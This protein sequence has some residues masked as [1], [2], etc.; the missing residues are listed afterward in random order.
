MNKIKLI[1][2]GSTGLIGHRIYLYLKKYK[3]YEIINIAFK[4]VLNENT[5]N[6]DLRDFNLLNNLIKKEKPDYII[7]AAG[8]LIADSDNDKFSAI[9]LNSL[10]PNWLMKNSILYNYKLIHISTDCVF[11]GKYGNY[12]ENDIP[13]GISIYSKTKSL[14]EIF[15]NNHVTIRTSV[16]GPEIDT[17]GGELFNWFMNQKEG[18]KG[19]TKSI[20]SGITT[21]ELA[22]CLKIIIDNKITGLYHLTNGLPI[23]KYDLLSKLNNYRQIPLDIIKIDG[24]VTNKSFIDTRTLLNYQIPDYDLMILDMITDIHNFPDLYSHYTLKLRNINEI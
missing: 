5:I 7:N 16:I 13:D 20:W 24:I 18:I 10:L 6:I 12:N 17:K 2:L 14:G 21:I 11:S 23:S 9:T 19:Y 22:K 15:S 4:R 8:L 3:E 1:L